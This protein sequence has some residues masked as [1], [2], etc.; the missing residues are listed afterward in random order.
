ML[1]LHGFL[2]LLG[3]DHETGPEDM[4]GSSL[5]PQH[6]L[7]LSSPLLSCLVFSSILCSNL[8]L[9]LCIDTILIKFV[10]LTYLASPPRRRWLTRKCG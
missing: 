6:P 8:V 3:Y 1:L 5:P 7:L 9:I 10:I 4:V 2:H